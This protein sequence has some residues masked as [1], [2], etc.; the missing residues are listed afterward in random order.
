MLP[1]LALI[2]GGLIPVQAAANLVL[3]DA[4]QSI[5]RAAL[6]LLATGFVFLAMV[7]AV[8][9][10]PLP[11]P[12]HLLGIPAHGFWGGPIVATYVLAIMFLAPIMGV[13]NAVRWIVTGQVLAALLIDHLGLFGA[14]VQTMDGS[15]IAGALLMIVGVG[16]ARG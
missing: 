5:L 10:V 9:R 12:A 6:I 2:A 15:R 3:V 8:T 7:A 16:L 14:S 1:V 11:G 4:L 13:G